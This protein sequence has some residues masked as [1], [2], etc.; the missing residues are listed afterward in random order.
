MFSK[1]SQISASSLSFRHNLR[2]RPN[3]PKASVRAFALREWIVND[4]R[5]LQWRENNSKAPYF[6]HLVPDDIAVDVLPYALR[7]PYCEVSNL[8]QNFLMR[9]RFE[10]KDLGP[11]KLQKS[12][13][14]AREWEDMYSTLYCYCRS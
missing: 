7:L 9:E 13:R 14:V 10:M 4:N 6:R 5:H 2:G 11:N 3:R 12:A 8:R 1:R